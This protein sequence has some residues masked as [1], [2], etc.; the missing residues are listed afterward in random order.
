MEEPKKFGIGD[1][2]VCENCGVATIFPY[3]FGYKL[4]KN[5]CSACYEKALEES[6][7]NG[8]DPP[9]IEDVVKEQDIDE[10]SSPELPKIKK[11]GELKKKKIKKFKKEVKK[12]NIKKK[13][14]RKK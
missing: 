11:R 1:E 4:S 12:K 8:N 5:Y 13:K 9:K 3:K 2:K 10:L 14:A 7:I 6:I